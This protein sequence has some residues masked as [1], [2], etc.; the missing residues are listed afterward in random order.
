MFLLILPSGK[1]CQIKASGRGRH[2]PPSS[3]RILFAGPWKGVSGAGRARRGLSVIQNFKKRCHVIWGYRESV[4]MWLRRGKVGVFC[5][6]SVNFEVFR[7][8]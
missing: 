6:K 8:F 5:G 7:G 1:F 3:A 4:K 2:L